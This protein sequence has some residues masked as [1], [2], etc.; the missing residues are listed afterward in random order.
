M[1]KRIRIFVAVFFAILLIGGAVFYFLRDNAR[2]DK[3]TLYGNV[4]IREVEAAFNDNGFVTKLLV[5]EGDQVHK[6]ELIALMDDQRYAAS[7]AAAQ[8]Q[9]ANQKQILAAL[10]AGTRPEQIVQAKA[11]M[12]A[13]EPVYQN[14]AANYQR[15]AALV[16]SSAA[17]RQQRDDAKAAYDNAKQNYEAAKQ[18][19]ILAVKGPRQ[20][21]IAAAQAAFDAAQAQ[22]TLAAVEFADTKLYAPADGIIEERILEPGDMATPQ[23]PVYTIALTNPLWVRAYVPET[24]LGKIIPGMAADITTDSYPGKVYHG[25][26]GYLSPTAEFTPKNVETPDLRAELVYQLRVYVCD[27]HNQLRLGMPATVTLN[28]THT[29]AAN[30]PRGPAVCGGDAAG[31]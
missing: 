14:D 25:W 2:T 16:L 17:S 19:Y 21:D 23:T 22:A 31:N 20:E 8:A 26:A 1:S 10:L 3:L 24:S 18:A 7:L 6:G 29:A 13:L 30:A 4:D 15:Y 9:A 11:Q 27:A 28:L 5:Q 12:D